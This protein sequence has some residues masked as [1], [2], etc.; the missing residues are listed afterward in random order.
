MIGRTATF[1]RRARR[2]SRLGER[3]ID[4]VNIF[5]SY[6][7]LS[8]LR[9]MG[10]NY[11]AR[12]IRSFRLELDGSSARVHFKGLLDF[13]ILEGVFIDREYDVSLKDARVIFDLGSN[14]GLTLIFFKL[15][16][17]NAMLFAFE[18]DQSNTAILRKNVEAFKDDVVVYEAAVVGTPA[19]SVPFFVSNEHWSSS[20]A[21]KKES[22]KEVNVRAVTLDE[23]MK[24]HAL[25]HID[26]LKFDIEGAEYEVLAG[27]KGL[28]C[29]RYIAGEVHEDL[30]KVP[31]AQFF[32]L[33]N[34]FTY[35]SNLLHRD[36]YTVNGARKQ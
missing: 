3:L 12:A 24:E 30:I 9:A 32:A 10:A 34:D 36:R 5:C 27:F 21:R 16:H 33:L 23:V 18:P 31:S 1:L 28:E 11:A 8:V 26:I 7:A 17:P 2:L 20:G 29:V 13:Y 4:R 19:E 35:T 15:R 25:Q 22:D 6:I 14:T